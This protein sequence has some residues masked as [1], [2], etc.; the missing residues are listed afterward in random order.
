[1]GRSTLW[2]VTPA[3]RRFEISAICFAQRRWACDQLAELGI[4]AEAVVIADDENLELAAEQGFAT[5]ERPNLTIG[6]KFN[7]G[8][9]FAAAEG[10]D[11][12]CPIGSDS[13]VD[14]AFIAAHLPE[15]GSRE[16]VYSRHYAVVRPDGA[17]RAQLVVDYEG[18]TTMFYPT[19]L[20]D[21]CRWRPIPEHAKRG[22]DGHTIA[23]ARRGGALT[24][25]ISEQHELETVSFQ[26]ELQVTD[27][28]ALIDRWGVG[29]TTRPF[30][31][32]DKH[33]P[34]ELVSRMRALYKD[35]A[36]NPRT[37]EK[38]A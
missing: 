31:G 27:Y 11:Y 7:D 13:W 26:T 24:F 17:R 15:L 19:S 34:R 25:T 37:P 30:A 35:R 38:L 33:Y 6:S 18:G 32:L 36:V 16:V 3:W 29:E 9:E 10:I 5:M 14:P 28:G 4:D 8:Y 12:V 23:A 2:F 20:F 22:C 1:M 21:H